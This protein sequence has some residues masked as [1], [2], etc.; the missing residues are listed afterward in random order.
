MILG[1]IF[2][3]ITKPRKQTEKES[4]AQYY[5]TRLAATGTYKSP[6]GPLEQIKSDI[7][8]DFFGGERDVDYYARKSER[9]AKSQAMLE[10]SMAAA[11]K[12]RRRKGRQVKGPTEEEL[13][14]QKRKD[15]G[16]KA[17]KKFEK[18][19]GERV[20]ALRKRY[21]TLLNV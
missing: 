2:K 15:E 11:A 1:A 8:G 21:K 6:K 12:D 14:L 9:S 20:A 4:Y 13:A 18:E 17:R 5:G 10:Q 19:K 7:K 16:Q 3:S